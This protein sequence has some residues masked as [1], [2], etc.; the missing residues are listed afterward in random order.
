VRRATTP[1]SFSFLL[2]LSPR[3]WRRSSRSTL[4]SVSL[5]KKME[6]LYHCYNCVCM[7]AIPSSLPPFQNCVNNIAT[8]NINTIEPLIA[9]SCCSGTS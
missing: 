1:F 7:V 3:G 8:S 5:Y 9:P 6:W 2:F 4:A